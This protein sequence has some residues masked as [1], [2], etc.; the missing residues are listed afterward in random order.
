M[1]VDPSKS[2]PPDSPA[3]QAA[4]SIFVEML[5][6]FGKWCDLLGISPEPDDKEFWRQI[7]YALALQCVLTARVLQSRAKKTKPIRWTDDEKR[8]LLSQFQK[9]M[10]G[11]KKAG[12]RTVAGAA[13]M[14]ARS[15]RVSGKSGGLIARY[16]E[17]RDW[18][19]DQIVKALL[20][21]SPPAQATGNGRPRG[22]RRTRPQN[23]PKA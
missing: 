7:S 12:G 8:R 22:G 16:Y 2:I 18:Q 11:G 10:A 17:A 6:L 15:G 13:E 3:D 5:V 14:L 19:R 1:A 20:S 9:A 4:Q 21:Q 23:K